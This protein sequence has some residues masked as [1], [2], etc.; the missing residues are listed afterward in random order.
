M[1]NYEKIMR[2]MTPENLTELINDGLNSC[3]YCALR[4]KELC[5]WYCH[6][7]IEQW[8]KQEAKEDAA[9]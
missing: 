9:D 1:T 8:L 6:G 4:E 7:G 5:G 2:D 3:A